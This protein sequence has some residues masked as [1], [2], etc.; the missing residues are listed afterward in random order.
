[1]AMGFPS[2]CRIP[3]CP[4]ATAP[5][6]PRPCPHPEL[7][8][9]AH[10]RLPCAGLSAPKVRRRAQCVNTLFVSIPP[11]KGRQ[12]VNPSIAATYRQS[13]PNDPRQGLQ[14]VPKPATGGGENGEIALR[15]PEAGAPLSF[16]PGCGWMRTGIL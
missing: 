11:K 14:M 7:R 15:R 9:T 3:G 13:H 5:P 6:G 10:R 12:K 2:P 1:M 8:E 16:F 4:S